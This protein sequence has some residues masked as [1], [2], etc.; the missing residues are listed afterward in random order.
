MSKNRTSQ[1]TVVIILVIAVIVGIY[2]WQQGKT[3]QDV[4]PLSFS[5]DD[6]AISVSK[7]TK[8]FDITAEQLAAI[9]EECG[10]KQTEAY[11]NEIATKFNNTEQTAY[12]FKYT[13]KSQESDTFVVTLVPNKPGYT[14]MAEFNRD[15]NICAAGGN[16]Y[17]KMLN[18][19]WL[20]FVNSCGSGFD[21]GSGN[22]IGCQSAQ[23]AIEPTLELK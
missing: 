6:S 16:F 15:F 7:D 5:N 1:R 18:D 21:D 10:N 23:A 13:K 8:S 9:A 12:N 17:P 2:F 14:S 11:F 4:D 19:Q 3:V 20:V 22:P